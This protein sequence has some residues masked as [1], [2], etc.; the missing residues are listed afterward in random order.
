MTDV[1]SSL[2]LCSVE[3]N[4]LFVVPLVG[5]WVFFVCLFPSLFMLL[6]FTI[7]CNMVDDDVVVSSLS[8][9]LFSLT[10]P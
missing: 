1:E 4:Y 2:S 10:D 6:L 9:S 8:L 3:R 5:Q 7:Y